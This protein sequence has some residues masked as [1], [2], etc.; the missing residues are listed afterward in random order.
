MKEKN[1]DR[2]QQKELYSRLV[3]AGSRSYY[4]DAKRDSMGS[5]YI[6]LSER[7]QSD[8]PSGDRQRIFVYEEDLDKFVSALLDVIKFVR[9]GEQQPSSTSDVSQ[10][11]E[12]KL[13]DLL[14]R[15][16]EWE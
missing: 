5:Q 15:E 16:D 10:L 8:K 4:I 9:L 14:E 2:V 13:S 11:G 1:R 12:I 7:R 3:K 6:V